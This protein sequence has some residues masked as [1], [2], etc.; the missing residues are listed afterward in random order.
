LPEPRPYPRA[1]GR[2]IAA[3]LAVQVCF[4]TFPVFGKIALAETPPMVLAA[5]RAIAGAIVLGLLARV[6]APDEAAPDARDRRML[7][8]LSLFGI[9]AN[10]T[11]FVSGLART[12]ATNATLCIASTPVFTMILSA[13]SGR[14]RPS[15]RRMLGVPIALAGILTLLDVTHL[16][17]S[18]RTLVG[19]LLILS[20]ALSYSIF[21][22]LSRDVLARRSAASF[23]A[24][25]FRYAA[26]P[27]LLL[28][29][30]DLSTFRPQALSGRAWIGIAGVLLLSTIVA[31]ALNSWALARMTATTVAM[32]IYVQPL[33]AISLARAVLGERPSP[34]TAVAAALIFAGVALT[35]WP[36]SLTVRRPPPR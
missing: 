8:V 31:Y 1:D 29:V 22:V 7:L 33:V 34:Q 3:L 35:T 10:Q 25:I 28:A 24:A 4:A 14:D 12:T 21:L 36:Q 30:P 17:F 26:L 13:L 23:T 5:M 11:L 19:N 20:N 16:D 9:V 18:D 6:L 32:Y 27:I 15:L 2:A